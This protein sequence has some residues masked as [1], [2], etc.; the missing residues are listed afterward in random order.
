MA[1]DIE[2]LIVSLEASTT[3]Y[4]R[5][6]A[7]ANGETEKRVRGMQRQFNA[8]SASSRA[9]EGR[10]VGAFGAVGRAF[11]VLGIALGTAS[12]TAMTS[13]WTDLNS[14]VNNA[15]GGVERGAAVLERLSEMSRR[16]YSSLEQTAEGYLG[17]AQA[18]TAL[19]YST[20]QQLDLIET[21]NN[22]LVVSA[23]RGERAASV[24]DA[25]SKAMA[26]GELR[27]DD[28]N[29]VI[30]SG[31]RLSK[32]LADAMGVSV[33]ELRTLGAEGKI[34]TDVMFGVTSQL[35]QLRI[36]A[37]AMPAT[38]SDGMVLLGNAVLEFVG[39]ADKAVGSS[40][41]LAQAIIEVS[42]AIR[43]APDEA[44]FDKVFGGLG[45]EI[46]RTIR[47]GARELEYLSKILDYVSN[48]RTDVVL[49]DLAPA[50]RDVSSAAAETDGTLEAAADRLRAFAVES[51][52]VFSPE[53]EAAFQDLITQLIEG[54]G[55]AELAREALQAL[56]DADPK[57]DIV[58]GEVSGLITW[59][60]QLR[61]AA[62]E[63][64]AAVA[65]AAEGRSSTTNIADQRA[66]QLSTRNRPDLSND[67]APGGP[68]RPPR[69]G[70]GGGG[71]GG[72]SPGERYG[73]SVEDMQRR[74]ALL[75][76]ENA[77]TA[78]LNPLV[79][80]YGY[81]MERL[82]AVQELQNAA[83]RAGLTLGPEQRAQIE[84]LAEAYATATAEAGRL[85]EQQRATVAQFEELSGA[86]RNALETIIDG[87]LE[88][89]DAGD[90]FADVLKDI[91]SQ[92]LNM[93]MNSLFGGGGAGG[94]GLFGQLFGFAK[95]GIAANGRPVK[96]F[97]GGGVSRTA[98]IFGEAGPEAAVPLPDGKRIPVDLRLAKLPSP[99]A[100]TGAMA[101]T[102]QVEGANGDQHVVDLVQ[103]GVTAGLKAYDGKMKLRVQGIMAQTQKS[104]PLGLR[105]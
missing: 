88:G 38:V 4:E 22:A 14:R 35:A 102:V 104:G 92:L 41:A 77:L 91:G 101:L 100:S 10:M 20:Q 23:V 74:L 34:T 64:N 55:N 79:H 48:S 62:N 83:T 89:K 39:K 7:K 53:V 3:K 28:L 80:D 45:D 75:R 24:M 82:H 90:I 13:A 15:A 84:G 21:L 99:G 12:I 61:D 73:Q 66:E 60:L 50:L 42:E 43:N 56:G 19:G 54:Q 27:G 95:G 40:S 46:A 71:G 9:M 32:A 30:Q 49:G 26:L 5:A 59:L 8:L 31:G 78:A 81:A 44:W 63:A 36:E 65:A 18:L 57:F 1:T 76:E 70:G 29:T 72:M 47:D 98:A 86:A 94:M 6:L 97:A 17:N 93:G 103:Q 105:R 51:R 68:I 85:A 52:G 37:D 16:T 67:G 58:V 11:G 69:S 33:N 87:F 25:W 96:T 2:R